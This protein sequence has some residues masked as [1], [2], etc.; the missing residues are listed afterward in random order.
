MKKYF[1]NVV[2][3]FIII[4]ATLF[5][6]T[7]LIGG[8]VLLIDWAFLQDNDATGRLILGWLIGFAFGGGLFAAYQWPWPEEE[9][10]EEEG[11]WVI[12]KEYKKLIRN[13]AKCNNCGD[14]IESKSVHD[15]VSCSCFKDELDNKGIFVDGGLDYCRRGGNLNDYTELGEYEEFRISQFKPKRS[16][17]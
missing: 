13:A 2:M 5:A 10:E 9:A 1:S 8:C 17:S 4:Y 7:L 16:Q 15:W 3:Y 14:V 6:L 11:D 12:H